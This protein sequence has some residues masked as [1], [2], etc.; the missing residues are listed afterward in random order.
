MIFNS[1]LLF[2]FKSSLL[3]PKFIGWNSPYPFADNLLAGI[4]FAIKNFSTSKALECDNSQFEG[5]LEVEIGILSVWPSIWI[6]Q[7]KSDGISCAISKSDLAI[8]DNASLPSACIVAL[9]ES[10][11]ISDWKIN[12]S[13][14]IWTSS[15]SEKYQ[16]IFQKIQTY[17]FV[18]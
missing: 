2:S 13:P 9:P 3:F 5:N 18:A 15:L 1:I 10:N 11:R 12:L 8:I 14:L 7:F 16:I 6:I 4:P 17:T